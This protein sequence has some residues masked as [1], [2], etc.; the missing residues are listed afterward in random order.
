MELD[1]QTQHKYLDI[2]D[3]LKHTLYYGL[4]KE[5]PNPQM[6]RLCP[7]FQHILSREFQSCKMIHADEIYATNQSGCQPSMRLFVLTFILNH[8]H[9]ENGWPFI[10]VGMKYTVIPKSVPCEHLS[11]MQFN[12][13]E[14]RYRDFSVIGTNP[15]P[16]S[17]RIC[18]LNSLFELLTV[19][20]FWVDDGLS[21]KSWKFSLFKWI[22]FDLGTGNSTFEIKKY[23][24][25]RIIVPFI[26]RQTFFNPVHLQSTLGSESLRHNLVCFIHRARRVPSNRL[27]MEEGAMD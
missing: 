21:D 26:F 5:H 17:I 1:P 27:K 11:K 14:N 15:R 7:Q 4:A 23:S 3:S 12:I 9:K 6:T 10:Q 8:V 16:I 24:I 13:Y 18:F 20:N 2:F 19:Q 22:G 25:R